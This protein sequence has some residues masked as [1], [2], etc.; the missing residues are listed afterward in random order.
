MSSVEV[1]N[2]L[3]LG[4]RSKAHIGLY[5][6]Y[7]LHIETMKDISSNS[8][9]EFSQCNVAVTELARRSMLEKANLNSL[10]QPRAEP[11]E[12]DRIR[13]INGLKVFRVN[14]MA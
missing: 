3:E 8:D 7:R 4:P 5:L 9:E 11:N 12:F 10:D 13:N 1:A 6:A 2:I 14:R